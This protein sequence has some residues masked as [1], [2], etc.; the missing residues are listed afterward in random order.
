MGGFLSGLHDYVWT[1]YDRQNERTAELEL[2]FPTSHTRNCPEEA[3]AVIFS[4][5]SQGLEVIIAI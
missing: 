2:I 5:A 4:E 1:H 3:R